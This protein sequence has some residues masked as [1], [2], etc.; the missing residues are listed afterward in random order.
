MIVVIAPT[1]RSGRPDHDFNHYWMIFLLGLGGV[2]N[3][4]GGLLIKGDG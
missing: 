1:S 4:G 2:L 3:S